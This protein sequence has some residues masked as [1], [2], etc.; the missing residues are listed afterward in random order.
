MES[1]E[2]ITTILLFV[3]FSRLLVITFRKFKDGYFSVAMPAVAVMFVF[4]CFPIVLDYT[5]GRPNFIGFAGFYQAMLSKPAAIYYNLYIIFVGLIFTRYIRKSK[6]KQFVVTPSYT[7]YISS[8]IYNRR[9]LLWIVMLLPIIAVAFSYHPSEYLDYKAIQLDHSIKFKDTHVFVSKATLLSAIAGS[10]LIYYLKRG[11]LSSILPK[12]ILYAVLL[13]IAFW[14][15]GKRGIWVKYAFNLLVFGWLLGK[16]KP[17]PLLRRALIIIVVLINMV[18]LYGK[19]FAEDV[20]TSRDIYSSFRINMGRDQTIKF[21]MYREF[22]ENKP[23]LEY[24][25][26]SFLFDAF[27]YVPRAIWSK[28]PYPYAVYFVTSVLNYPPEPIGWSFTTCILEEF[29]SNFGIIG[30]LLAPL[31]LLWICKVGDRSPNTITKFFAIIVIV[32]FLF[33]QLAAF[34]PLFLV[35]LFL[36]LKEKFKKKK[37]TIPNYTASLNLT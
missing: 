20:A 19:D 31:F 36:F 28:K 35:F 37:K 9:Y 18:L 27:F 6:E 33:T 26:Q 13:F 3:V 2:T 32:F 21:T 11:K 14:V 24:R 17:G 22:V 23:I 30:I 16:L 7:N 12:Y 15:D 1:V 5:I 34:M 10:L 8:Q 4:L 25:G 29:I